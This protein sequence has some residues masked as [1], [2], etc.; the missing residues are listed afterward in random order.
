VGGALADHPVSLPN[1]SVSRHSSSNSQA[2]VEGGSTPRAGHV[3][4]GGGAAGPGTLMRPIAC[5]FD[6]NYGG[7]V[8]AGLKP[9]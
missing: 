3:G 8:E 2:P 4:S 1:A 9:D 7:D 5:A 6:Q